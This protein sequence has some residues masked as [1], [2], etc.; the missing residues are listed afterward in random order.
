MGFQIVNR[1]C[2]HKRVDDKISLIQGAMWTSTADAICGMRGG[3]WNL[4]IDT[5][6]GVS[7]SRSYVAQVFGRT[8][9]TLITQAHFDYCG[10][11]H[12]FSERWI[13][14]V[15]VHEMTTGLGN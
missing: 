6:L 14:R 12:D 8:V 15:E 2:G 13:H 9:T 7:E 11:F 10:S 4:L 5:G 1:W 3:T